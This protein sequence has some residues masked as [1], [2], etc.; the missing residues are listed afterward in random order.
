MHMSWI[1]Y[2]GSTSIMLGHALTRHICRYAG[3]FGKYQKLPRRAGKPVHLQ[4][5]L[6]EFENCPFLNH[7]LFEK[8]TTNTLILNLLYSACVLN[9]NI[10]ASDNKICDTNL[11]PRTLFKIKRTLFQML[12]KQIVCDSCTIMDDNNEER[13]PVLL[14]PPSRIE[15]RVWS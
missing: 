14:T 6:N 2:S 8:R 11:P 7:A 13:E 10:V 12:I 5:G 3:Y 1:E 4:N 15:L 9:S